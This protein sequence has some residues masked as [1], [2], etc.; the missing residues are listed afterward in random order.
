MSDNGIEF[1]ESVTSKQAIIHVAAVVFVVGLKQLGND[2]FDQ[3]HMLGAAYGQ[4]IQAEVAYYFRHRFEWLTE[5]AQNELAGVVLLDSHM[6]EAT[7]APAKQF[8]I[9][10]RFVNFIFN[11][12]WE[13]VLSDTHFNDSEKSFRD[14]SQLRTRK[15][16]SRNGRNVHSAS[17]RV[18]DP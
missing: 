5:F 11:V 15:L 17:T 10:Q 2:R 7:G 8:E 18:I 14:D 3:A 6:H 12:Q 1:A 16:P 4:T 13:F 9:R